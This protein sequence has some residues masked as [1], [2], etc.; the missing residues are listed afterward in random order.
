MKSELLEQASEV[1]TEPTVLIN[2]VS[3]RV[4]QLNLGRTPLVDRLPSQGYADVA[5][6]EI[7]EGKIVLDGTKEAEE[8]KERLGASAEV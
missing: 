3:R 5:L 1:I 7:I 4:K 2:M 6:R 8:A